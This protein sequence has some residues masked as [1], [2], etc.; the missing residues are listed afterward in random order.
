MRWSKIAVLR[1]RRRTAIRRPPQ[2]ATMGVTGR[3]CSPLALSRDTGQHTQYSL[4]PAGRRDPSLLED[5]DDLR[6]YG[7]KPMAC[8]AGRW[9]HFNRVVET[10][11]GPIRY[12]R[13]YR[14][15][16]LGKKRAPVSQWV[17][18]GQLSRCA[19]IRVGAA[20]WKADTLS[21]ISLPCGLG[22]TGSA[23]FAA[24]SGV[25]AAARI[26]RTGWGMFAAPTSPAET[27]RG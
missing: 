6:G 22:S 24:S 20:A 18:H 23:N 8:D 2:S 13:Q 9:L 15:W 4:K 3:R 14:G 17:L 10:G 7:R 19:I 1:Q 25:M 21:Q 5:R 26:T 11:S 12:Y 27:E 16:R